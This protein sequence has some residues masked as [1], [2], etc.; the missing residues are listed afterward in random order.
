MFIVKLCLL[1][2]CLL[3]D[4]ICWSKETHIDKSWVLA[5]LVSC[6]LVVSECLYPRPPATEWDLSSG[7][8]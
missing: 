7:N 4:R 3:N 8:V 2:N 6:Q 5:T 1:S